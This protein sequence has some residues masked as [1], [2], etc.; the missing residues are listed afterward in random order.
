MGW[1]ASTG[2]K[3]KM[4]RATVHV[5]IAYLDRLF[6]R[7]VPPKEKWRML[8]ISCLQVAAKYEEA[9]ENVPAVSQLSWASGIG[10]TIQT[11]QRWEVAVLEGLGW[12]LTCI[13]PLHF[14]EYYLT[15]G[16][17]FCHDTVAG[18]RHRL[19][20]P[21]LPPLPPGL[22]LTKEDIAQK[23]Q[24]QQQQQIAPAQLRKHAHFFASY[25]IVQEF[26]SLAPYPPS[27][28]AALLLYLA[29]LAL[30]VSP[31]WRPELASLTGV[32]ED[33]LVGLAS[34][35]LK[36][37][38]L[39]YPHHPLAAAG[40]P[41]PAAATGGLSLMTSSALRAGSRAGE[42]KGG[43]KNYIVAASG[44]GDGA[45]GGGGAVSVFLPDPPPFDYYLM[46]RGTACV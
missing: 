46:P 9:E 37:F 27:F 5:A 23:E 3:L 7:H 1:L 29:R 38:R 24:Q 8:A 21:P 33:A 30:G 42:R 36:S 31:T 11:V 32:E 15:R 35:M 2:D 41:A 12:Q 22:L 45:G 40:A 34:Q 26:T 6:Q 43:G 10:L 17:L 16:V 28:V 19:A 25:A 13:V 39:D 44:M 14:I 20:P 18:G 4:R